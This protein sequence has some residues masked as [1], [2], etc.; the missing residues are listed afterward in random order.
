ME[1]FEI[2]QT[3]ISLAMTVR[4]EDAPS[5]FDSSGSTTA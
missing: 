4:H 3:P 5:R 2:D 1:L